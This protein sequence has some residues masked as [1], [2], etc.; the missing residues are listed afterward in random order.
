MKIEGNLKHKGVQI[1]HLKEVVSFPDVDL[2]ALL[3]CYICICGLSPII[4]KQSLEELF[5]VSRNPDF[6]DSGARSRVECYFNAR[7]YSCKPLDNSI[8]RFT[9]NG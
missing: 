5:Q 7:M 9:L 8:E 4:R 1:I 2:V 3:A 6:R